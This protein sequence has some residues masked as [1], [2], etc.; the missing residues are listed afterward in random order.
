MATQAPGS[1]GLVQ[2]FVNTLEMEPRPREAD[3][4]RLATPEA[5]AGWLRERDLLPESR[6]GADDL[7]RAL[8]LR[9]AI[10]RLLLANNGAPAHQADLA[11]LDRVARE[12]GLRPRFVAADRVVLEPAVGGVIGALGRLLAAVSEAMNQGTWQR[13]K[14]CGDQGCRWAFYDS[15][16]NRSGHWCSMESCGNRAK[17]RQF[18]QRR[19]RSP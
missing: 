5:L 8:E 13:L 1:L 16:K 7:A 14:A 12:S 3:V 17:A 15:S 19:R 4:E 9:E 11:L 2:D 6:A 10:R 18:R